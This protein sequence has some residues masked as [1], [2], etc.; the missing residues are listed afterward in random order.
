MDFFFF[1]FFGF[2]G[3]GGVI[4]DVGETVSPTK[5]KKRRCRINFCKEK[6]KDERERE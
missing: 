6:N 2:K 1:F 4:R 5:K 3:D